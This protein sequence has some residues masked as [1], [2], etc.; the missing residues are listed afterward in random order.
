MPI[1]IA[2]GLRQNDLFEFSCNFNK[3]RD[4]EATVRDRQTMHSYVPCTLLEM[5]FHYFLLVL[6]LTEVCYNIIYKRASMFAYCKQFDV[7]PQFVEKHEFCASVCIFA[8][9]RELKS[10]SQI[11]GCISKIYFHSNC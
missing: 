10:S 4:F 5:I 1:Q 11:R 6:N 9:F 8:E 2:T 3:E 7:W